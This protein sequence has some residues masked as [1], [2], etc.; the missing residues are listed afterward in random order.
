MWMTYRVEEVTYGNEEE[1]TRNHGCKRRAT[2]SS[3]VD[4]SCDADDEGTEGG[5]NI[6]SLGDEYSGTSVGGIGQ[7]RKQ[8]HHRQLDAMVVLKV[9]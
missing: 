9:G 7:A 4:V 8:D 5:D 1:N 6:R 3:R 2:N